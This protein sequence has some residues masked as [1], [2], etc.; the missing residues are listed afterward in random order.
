MRDLEDKNNP[1][2]KELAPLLEPLDPKD[3][4]KNLN[5]FFFKFVLFIFVLLFFR[6]RVTIRRS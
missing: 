6:F 5:I 4:I 1:A 2:R 3:V